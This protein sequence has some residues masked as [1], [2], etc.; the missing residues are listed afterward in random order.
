MINELVSGDVVLRAGVY[1]ALISYHGVHE[2]DHYPF[3]YD[4]EKSA[5]RFCNKM[6]KQI[7]ESK[8]W[9]DGYFKIEEN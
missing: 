8:T 2:F 7:E 4:D 9:W 3:V 6:L 5:K 1:L